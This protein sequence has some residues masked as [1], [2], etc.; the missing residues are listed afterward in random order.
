[1]LS[2]FPHEQFRRQGSAHS[3]EPFIILLNIPVVIFLFYERA[4]RRGRGGAARLFFFFFFP[5][6]QTTS[7]IGQ[8]VK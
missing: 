3:L 4:A 1:M 8:R 2:R 5:V 7:G 6:Q